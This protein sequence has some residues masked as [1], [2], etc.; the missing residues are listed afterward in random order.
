M[1]RVLFSF[2][3]LIVLSMSQGAQA[4][5][6]ADSAEASGIR[7]CKEKIREN[8]AIFLKDQPHVSHDF[9]APGG[10]RSVD[11]RPFLSTAFRNYSDVGL[12][13]L[14][15]VATRSDL[16]RKNVKCDMQISETF[17]SERKSCEAWSL[18]LS[19]QQFE[20]LPLAPDITLM[21]NKGKQGVFSF[22]YLTSINDGNGCLVSR[23]MMAYDE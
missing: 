6:P 20:A 1:I 23:R 8:T 2:L 14:S 7:T 16:S 22:Y 17:A 11:K 9:V 3:V 19:K 18:E 5:Q 12:A 13:H 15:I 4:V 21:E 10:K